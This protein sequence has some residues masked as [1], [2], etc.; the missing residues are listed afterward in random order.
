[1]A[2]SIR[3]RGNSY[4]IRYEGPPG[5]DGQ[6]RQV[7]ETVHGSRRDAE[8][9]LRQRLQ[10][11]EQGTHVSRSTITLREYLE[12]WIRTYGQ[13]NVEPT[14]ARGYQEKFRNYIYGTIGG[15]Q[16]SQLRP[17]HA[18]R[19]YAGMMERGLSA[20]TV[21][22]L[23]RALN[24]A[25]VLAVR[26]RRISHNPLSMVT[27]PRVRKTSPTMWSV[28]QM[29]AFLAAAEKED[30]REWF[31]LAIYTGLRRSE[32]AG[33]KWGHVDLRAGWLRVVEKLVNVPGAGLVSG[34]P[35][36]DRS[37]R[38]LSISPEAVTIFHRQL[39]RQ[40]RQRSQAGELWSETG[41]VFT[42]A[43]GQP[44]DPN[45][46]TK[47]FTHIVRET[48]LPRL[49]LRDMR[50]AHATLLLMDNVHLKV[51]S[52][53]LGHSTVTVTADIYSH[54]LPEI[55]RQASLVIDRMLRH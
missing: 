18:D 38:R 34:V 28:E 53:R 46:V 31:E 2:G 3:K 43:V 24:R 25:L 32:M 11:V 44:V 33:L 51:V 10:E 42:S 49:T 48:G 13:T 19:V 55:D 7:H 39:D 12:E 6:R 1:M 20:N 9:L 5:A 29:Q 45:A 36:T 16:L 14:T 52:E 23:H 27:P 37:R 15:V 40:D 54:V 22:H 4:R 41:H 50:H 26:S 8:R 21:L 35:K 47:A 17:E 30:L